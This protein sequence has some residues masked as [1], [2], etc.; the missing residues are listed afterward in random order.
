[1]RRLGVWVG[2]ALVLA[3]G[4]S[5]GLGQGR[6]GADRPA[7][8]S[9]PQAFR[10]LTQKP[11]QEELK[12]TD[13]QVKKTRELTRRMR[14]QLVRAVEDGERAKVFEIIRKTEPD[15]YALLTPEQG[16]RL[17]EICLQERE[18]RAFEDPA[19]ARELKITDGQKK[20]LA[21]LQEEAKKKVQKLYEG[22]AADR[23]E[24]RKKRGELHAQTQQKILAILTPEQQ[25]RWKAM[26]GAPFQGAIRRG[27]PAPDRE[28]E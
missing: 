22:E 9:G 20:Q 21:A 12:L 17:K 27:P 7:G 3:V 18:T 28:R 13:D 23:Q 6:F 14:D 15:L 25:A 26:T 4:A 10:L 11:V 16:K 24:V 5:P 8:S 19:V 2:P 1:M